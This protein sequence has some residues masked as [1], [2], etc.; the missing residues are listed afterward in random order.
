MRMVGLGKAK[1][2][3]MTDQSSQ[4]TE[5]QSML[6]EEVKPRE[7]LS[8]KR[9]ERKEEVLLDSI[10]TSSVTDDDVTKQKLFF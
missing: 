4:G 1:K 9:A 10:I 7:P 5:D 6:V 3:S 2:E 8:G